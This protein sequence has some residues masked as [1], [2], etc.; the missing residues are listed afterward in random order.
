MHGRNFA[1]NVG[2]EFKTP[3]E[4]F[5][6]EGPQPFVRDFEPSDYLSTASTTSTNASKSQHVQTPSSGSILIWISADCDG[7]EECS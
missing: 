3:E 4:Y 7:Q 1:T 2:I 5:L 6:H